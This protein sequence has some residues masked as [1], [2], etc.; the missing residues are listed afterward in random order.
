MMMTASAVN[1]IFGGYL[2]GGRG[3]ARWQHLKGASG[4]PC[5]ELNPSDQAD[6]Q[7]LASRELYHETFAQPAGIESD[8]SLWSSN[9]IQPANL[10]GL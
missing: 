2:S 5:R 3:G 6:Q 4:R 1:D 7:L 8:V 9:P 10:F